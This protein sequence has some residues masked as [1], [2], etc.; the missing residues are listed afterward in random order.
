MSESETLRIV[1]LG[2]QGDGV[3]ETARGPVYVPFTLPGEVVQAQVDGERGRLLALDVA[4][5]DR[6]PP[7]CRH[8]GVCGGCVLQH[9]PAAEYRDW[10]RRQVAAAFRSRGI[11]TEVAELASAAG[12]RRRATFSARRGQQTLLLGFHEAGTHNLVD[13]T[14]CPVLAPRI[15]EALPHL[16]AL[17]EPL[18]SRRG[19]LR[20]TVTLTDGGLDVAFWDT[21]HELTPD[22]RTDIARLAKAARLARVSVAADP[23]YEAAAPF[24]RIGAAEVVPPPGA[25]LQAVAAAEAMMAGLIVEALGKA[26]TVADLFSGLGAFALRIAQTA[27]VFAAD[28]DKAAIAAMVA[29]GRKAQGL[30]PIEARVRDLF[31]EPLSPLELNDFAAVVFDPP[32]AGAEAQARMLAKSKVK[33]V[34]AVSCN[35]ATLA[36]DVRILLDGGYR[37]TALTPIDQFL[38]SPHIEAVAVLRR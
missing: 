12:P 26:K 5:P 7:V 22:M 35:P 14:Q 32:R 6:V 28:S 38:F 30:K 27:K 29:A 11:E 16:K 19:E 24:L 36:R 8:F 13:I 34:V 9:M 37:L 15:V 25:F 23:V 31:L 17:A 18:S 21:T 10:K 2:A 1:R 33:T 4:S 3:A 20:L